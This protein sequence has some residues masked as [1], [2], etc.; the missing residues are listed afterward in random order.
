VTAISPSVPASFT[1]LDDATYQRRKRAWAMYDWAN[2]AFA[3][4]ILAAILPAYYSRVAG[5]NLPTEAT[6]TGYWSLSLAISLFIVAI[7][8][9]IL[10]TISDVVRGKKKFLSLFVGIGVVGTGLL[11]FVGTGDW[12]LA[13]IL[14]IVGRI[15]FSASIVFYDALL[16]H[17][18]RPED[19][20]RL[21]T[22]GYAMGYLGGGLL[23]GINVA[24]I[25]IWGGEVGARLSFMSVAIWW[26]VFSIPVL[27]IVP[28]PPAAAHAALKAGQNVINASS[29]QLRSTLRDL[30]QYRELFKFLIAFLIYNDGIGTFIGMAVIYGAELG[31]DTLEL[32]AAL[33]LVQFAGIPFSFVFGRLPY[34]GESNRAFFLAFIVWN[35]VT[36]PLVGIVGKNV[37]DSSVVGAALPDYQATS[38]AVGTDV[39]D[40]DEGDVIHRGVLA[41]ETNYTIEAADVWTIETPSKAGHTYITSADPAAA[42]TITY[43]GRGVELLYSEGSDRGVFRVVLDGEPYAFEDADEDLAVGEVDAYRKTVRWNNRLTVEADE[44][45]E[46]TLLVM[47]TGQQNAESSGT[48][49]DL[50]QIEVLPPP[51]ESSLPVILGALAVIEVAGLAFAWLFGSQVFAR[52]AARLT[53]K[54]AVL[55]ALAAYAVVAIW[56]YFLNAVIEFWLLAWLVSMVQGGSQALS[57]SLYASMSPRAKSGEFFGFFSVME[58]FAGV[59]GPILFAG[60]VAIFGSSRPAILSLIALFLIGGW[61]LLWVDVD[62]GRRVAQAE[63]AKLL[64][65]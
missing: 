49:I 50:G 56:G 55:L 46:H 57:R 22:T 4:T 31:F 13:S 15:G 26:A 29:S 14:F 9:P 37:L 61:L 54:R 39:Y 11:V 51:R 38:D 40:A 59:L 64:Q 33:L 41:G 10:G 27:R 1:G 35:L 17:V 7:L 32:V 24:M 30:R 48:R 19:V 34:E 6:A 28:E 8:S 63:D 16:P 18:A 23:L 43:N 21:S 5:A 36:L 65:N 53:T 25:A 47:N 3:T 20:D 12:L 52:A 42:Y 2:S 58:K 60:A 44:A 45:G 62:E